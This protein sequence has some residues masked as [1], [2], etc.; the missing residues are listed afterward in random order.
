MSQLR[1]RNSVKTALPEERV[2]EDSNVAE[3]MYQRI[4]FQVKSMFNVDPYNAKHF[5]KCHYHVL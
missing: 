2:K 5:L 1:F 3:T 4:H